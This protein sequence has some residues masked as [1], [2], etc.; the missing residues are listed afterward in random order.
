MH[1]CIVLWETNKNSAPTHVAAYLG[2]VPQSKTSLIKLHSS[3]CQVNTCAN[4]IVQPSAKGSQQTT[5]SNFI[6]LF[7][8]NHCAVYWKQHTKLAKAGY[9]K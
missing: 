5:S 2:A 3:W 6:A 7:L 1:T 9:W 8:N 4:I